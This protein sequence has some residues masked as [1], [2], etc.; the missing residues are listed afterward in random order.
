MPIVAIGGLI[1]PHRYGMFAN[2]VLD[3]LIEWSRSALGKTADG[4]DEQ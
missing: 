1:S 4:S 3:R 2:D